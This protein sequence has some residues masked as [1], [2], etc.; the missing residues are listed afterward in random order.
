MRSG[1]CDHWVPLFTIHYLRGVQLRLDNHMSYTSPTD[2]CTTN[3]RPANN[4]NTV[5]TEAFDISAVD[6][7]AVN[8]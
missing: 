1:E 3:D 6:S 5:D 8:N 2:F 7:S 4:S